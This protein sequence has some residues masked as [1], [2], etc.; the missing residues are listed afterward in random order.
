MKDSA[1]GLESRRLLGLAQP[2]KVEVR[3]ADKV[4]P[5]DFRAMVPDQGPGFPLLGTRHVLRM[6]MSCAISMRAELTSPS[7]CRL[8]LSACN[9]DSRPSSHLDKFAEPGAGAALALAFNNLGRQRL[10]HALK[11]S[12]ASQ[13]LGLPPMERFQ[14]GLGS[15]LFRLDLVLLPLLLQQVSIVSRRGPKAHKGVSY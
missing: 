4:P 11:G 9:I 10:L 12:H 6:L 5:S 3:P 13:T 1:L 8:G 15:W 14:Y 7:A 2:E